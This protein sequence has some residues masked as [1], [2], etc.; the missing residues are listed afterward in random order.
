MLDLAHA[1]MLFDLLY[2][3][4]DGYSVSHEAR[5]E[6]NQ[7]AGVSD[8]LYGE[9][10]FITWNGIL[11]KVQ[12]KENGVFLDIGSGT[13]R[14]VIASRLLYNFKKVIGVELLKGLHNQACEIKEHFDATISHQ[15]E[16]YTKNCNIEFLNKNVF[17]I[18]LSEADF[19]FM[20]HPFKDRELFKMIEEKLA[21]E[22]KPQSK[23]V[24][25]IRSLEDKKF[26]S[27]G[28]AQYDFSWG[29]STAFFH[30]V[31]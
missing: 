22:L 17:D 1:S 5:K 30:E 11:K 15:I 20:N 13:G 3:K 23:I 12:P 8:I 19:V 7:D 10:P 6:L 26:K 14:I 21:K 27:L 9:L 24:T 29:K 4:I 28:S 16:D 18:D 2:S 31:K 25:I